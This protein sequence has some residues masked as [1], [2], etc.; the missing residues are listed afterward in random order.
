MTALVPFSAREFRGGRL[1]LGPA[2]MPGIRVV[3]FV[4]PQF[5]P[6]AFG[7]GAKLGE[8]LRSAFSPGINAGPSATRRNA[9]LFRRKRH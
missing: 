8:I 3:A 2:F 7:G 4:L 6:A 5:R 9:K 1:A